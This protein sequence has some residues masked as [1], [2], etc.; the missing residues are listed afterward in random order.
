[1]LQDLKERFVLRQQ[2]PQGAAGGSSWYVGYEGSSFAH[3]ADGARVLAHCVGSWDSAWET[4]WLGVG[5][6]LDF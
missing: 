6:T 4:S 3:A 2:Q 1:M 5:T